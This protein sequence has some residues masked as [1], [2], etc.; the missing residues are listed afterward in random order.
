M[1]ALVLGCGE[2]GE[3]VI[4]DL[5]RFGRFSEIVVGTRTPEKVEQLRKSLNGSGATITGT[6]VDAGSIEELTTL[7]HGVDVVVN[8]VGPNYRYEIPVARAAI[9][10]GVNLVDLNDEFETTI[11]MFELDDQAKSAGVTVV[12]GLGGSP[13]INNILVRA[14]ANQL[15]TVEEIHTAWVM[16]AADPGGLALCAH[17]LHSLSWRALTYE[18]GRM[19][20]VR[21]FVDGR[22]R[23]EFPPPVGPMDVFH[24]GHPEPIMLSR[25]F[26]GVHTVDD[27]ATF[28][29]PEINGLILRLGALVRQADGPLQV[30]GQAIEVMDFAAAYLRAQCKKTTGVPREAALHVTVKGLKKGRSKRVYFSSAGLLAAATGIPAS[31]GAIMLAEGKIT[32]KGVA[33]PE[34]CIE[35]DDFL[36]EILTRRNVAKLNGWVED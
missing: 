31:I 14:A 19:V 7:M 8:S 11:Q 26:P 3:E 10:A 34:Q 4:Q 18:N 16:S 32:A 25:S 1:K 21:S 27:K 5:F 15:D 23:I 6:S 35:A 29:P 13:G 33:P 24:V 17:L 36:Y 2:M 9:T 28:N 20:E 12:L 22:E 30:G